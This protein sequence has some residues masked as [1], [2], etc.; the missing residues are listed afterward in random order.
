MWVLVVLGCGIGNLNSF[1][2]IPSIQIVVLGTI[3]G[4]F[5]SFPMKTIAK[6]PSVT[7]KAFTNE[8]SDPV[9]VIKQI[10]DFAEKARKEGILAL[11]GPVNKVQDEFMKKGLMLAVDG[12]EPDLIRD[13]LETDIGCIEERHAMGSAVYSYMASLAP[14]MGMLG[15]LVGLVLMLGN[16]SDIAS[17]G[18]NMAVALITTFY[19][20]LLA[21]CV[22]TPIANSLEKK[23]AEEALS[24]SLMVEGIM[25][26]SAG[27]NPRIVEQKL[28][29]YLPPL[30][31]SKVIKAR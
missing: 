22:C 24:K 31:R 14:A 13:I 2:D 18:P 5:A 4:A 25:A 11:E 19:G 20:S 7:V 23:N 15:T 26:I 12:T 29:T 10:V 30:I 21:N 28:S 3:S 6:L 8:K 1:I 9:M 27:D 17:V 16:L